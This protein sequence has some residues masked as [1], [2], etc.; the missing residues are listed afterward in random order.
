MHTAAFA[1]EVFG[2]IREFA[3]DALEGLPDEALTWQPADGANTIAWLVWH[4][5]RVQDDHIAHLAGSPQVW[6]ADPAWATRF[7][8]EA[9]DRRIGYGDTA[10]QVAQFA[11]AD[12]TVM[13]EY[14]DAVTDRTLA[15]LDG[16]G[17]EAHWD[18][19]VDERWDPPV[20]ARVRLASVVSDDLQHV[21]QIAYLRGLYE[22]S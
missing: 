16:V 4:L 22:R 7:G 5:A 1:R 11:P 8:L 18:R 12:A 17:D 21:G 2:N 15:Y 3:L 9:G 19:V 6:D 10:E 20:T 14:L 13:T